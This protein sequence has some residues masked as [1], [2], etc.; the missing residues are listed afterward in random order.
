[1]RLWR[2][3]RQHTPGERRLDMS[4]QFFYRAEVKSIQAWILASDRLKE[5]KGG[6]AIVDGL[7]ADAQKLLARLG[8]DTRDVIA[9]AGSVQVLFDEQAALHRFAAAWPLVV[10][11]HGD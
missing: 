10:A 1:M 4:E 2:V 9:A 11:L 5:L 3:L 7:A 6:S 8:V